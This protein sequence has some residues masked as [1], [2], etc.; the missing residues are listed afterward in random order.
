MDKFFIMMKSQDGKNA[1]TIN[2]SDD[3]SDGCNTALYD[4]L[5]EAETVAGNHSFCNAWGYEIFQFG[6]AS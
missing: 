2:S 5:E 4:T 3:F 1:N 6:Q